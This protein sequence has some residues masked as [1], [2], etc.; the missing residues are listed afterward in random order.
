[1]DKLWAPWRT[2]YIRT[3]R[4][5]ECIFCKVLKPGSDKYLIFRTKY[6]FAVLNIFPYNNGHMLIAPLRHIADISSLNKEEI[7]DLIQ[8]LIKGKTLLDKVLKAEGYNIGIN[9]GKSAGAGITDHLHLHIVP[10]WSGDTNF[11]TTVS[12]IKV[13]SQSLKE[14]H[15]QLL[16]AQSKRHQRT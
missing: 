13:I 11:M 9:L 16:Y 6:S 7:L 14:L 4:Q 8:S 1:M 12:G 2:K 10:R 3:T 5:K 15:K